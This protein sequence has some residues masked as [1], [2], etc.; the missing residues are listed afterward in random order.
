MKKVILFLTIAL[1]FNLALQAQ[2]KWVLDK[3]HTDI[4]FTAVHYMITEVDGEF[5]DFEGTVTSPSDD[6]DGAEVEFTAKVAS[7]DTDNERRDNHLKADDFFNAETYPE[8][9][10]KGKITKEGDKHYLVGDFTM[11]DVTKP[12]KFDVKY[13]GSVDL[14]KRGKKAGFKVTGVV[15]RFEYGLKYNRVL[16]AGGLAVSQEIQI[17][18]NIELNEAK[19]N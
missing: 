15:D 17:T 6:F 4:R 1:G 16:E 8:L 18:C 9:S 3:S 14:G 12:I 10:F 7:I 13:N 2:T 11:R 19:E 5:K